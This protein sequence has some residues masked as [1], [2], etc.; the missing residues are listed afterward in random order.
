[1]SKKNLTPGLWYRFLIQDSHLYG[2]WHE[3]TE[4]VEIPVLAGTGLVHQLEFKVVENTALAEGYEKLAEAQDDED[5][6]FHEAQTAR[7]SSPNQKPLV[8][9]LELAKSLVTVSQPHLVAFLT[10]LVGSL[11]A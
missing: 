1:M 8:D 5:K 3:Y 10:G 6:A 11:D 4:P 9:T 7:R 2:E